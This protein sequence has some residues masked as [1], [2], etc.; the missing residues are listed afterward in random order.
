MYIQLEKQYTITVPKINNVTIEFDIESF[1]KDNDIKINDEKDLREVIQD[2]VDYDCEELYYNQ[3]DWDNDLITYDNET[4]LI[5]NMDALVKEF[6][7]L[8]PSVNNPPCCAIAKS[9][10]Y[11]Y[12]P[13][14]GAKLSY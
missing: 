11:N 5:L 4:N 3:D 13:I 8:I 2:W 9:N 14:C 1:I 10:K 12:C 6:F 7:H